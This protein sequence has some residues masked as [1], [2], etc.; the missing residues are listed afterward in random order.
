MLSVA[1]GQCLLWFATVKVRI[2]TADAVT[3]LTIFYKRS[4]CIH[5]RLGCMYGTIKDQP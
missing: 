4:A 5:C 1:E 3:V 2:R